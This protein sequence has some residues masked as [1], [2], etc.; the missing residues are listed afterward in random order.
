MKILLTSPE[1]DWG[2]EYHQYPLGAL[3]LMSYLSS[4]CDYDIRF[5]DPRVDSSS[6]KD[7][8]LDFNPDVIGVSFT[9]G[10]RLNAIKIAQ[11]YNDNKRLI[12]AGGF[13]PTCR[14]ED[15]LNN[16]FDVVV[17]GDGEKTFPKIVKEYEKRGKFRGIFL[18]E[19]IED[20]DKL[21]FPPRH[22]LFEEY[23]YKYGAGGVLIASRGC[24][25]GCKFCGSAKLGIRRRSPKNVVSELEDMVNKYHENPIHFR[26]D[27][28]TAYS[29]WARAIAGE[30]MKRELSFNW[31]VN[32]KPDV[33]DYEMFQDLR[34]AG[35]NILLFGIESGSL[36]ILERIG[37]K[38]KIERIIK[39]FEVI[40]KIKGDMQ[41]RTD[42]IIGLPGSYEEHLENIELMKKLQPEQIHLNLFLPYPGTEYG[43]NPEKY[44]IKIK[45]TDWSEIGTNIGVC[46]LNNLRSFL[47]FDYLSM[48]EIKDIVNKTIDE[49]R[50]L[51]YRTIW[52]VSDRSNRNRGRIIRTFLDDQLMNIQH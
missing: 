3:Y 15:C 28:F 21:P 52:E 31:S 18:G 10:S 50:K 27:S 6:L 51:G 43:D 25:G 34:N 37:K 4:K 12:V 14:P 32:S 20:L 2:K 5:Y 26:D 49:M 44:G 8:V 29:E 41:T 47:E 19:R 46:D 36:K 45:N 11:R 22:I 9:T 35:C 23:G 40:R 13:H 38:V 33:A 39:T 1:C 16:G 42:W 17:K 30:I 24:Y 7:I 48:G